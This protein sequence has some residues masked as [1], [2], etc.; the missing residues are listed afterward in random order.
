M[1]E[2][3]SETK[4]KFVIIGGIKISMD[5]PEVQEKPKVNESS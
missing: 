4:E 2:S 5:K 3:K 1:V